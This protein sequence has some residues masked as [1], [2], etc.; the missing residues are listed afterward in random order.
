VISVSR[1]KTV[2]NQ[3][4]PAAGIPPGT[5]GAAHPQRG[6]VGDRPEERAV[7]PV[8]LGADLR[9]AQLPGREGLADARLLLAEAPL[10][11][12]RRHRVAVDR[13]EHVKSQLPALA[14]A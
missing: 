7:D 2:M 12:A 3:G 13:R 10:G 11:H 1:P 4:I 8:P 6:E 5:A 9:H 14:G